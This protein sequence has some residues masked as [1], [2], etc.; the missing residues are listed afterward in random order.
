MAK[1]VGALVQFKRNL[2]KMRRGTFKSTTPPPRETRVTEPAP[3]PGRYWWQ[4]QE[5]DAEPM[6]P[7]ECAAEFAK[8]PLVYGGE[9]FKITGRARSDGPDQVVAYTRAPCTDELM[10]PH[11]EAGWVD[12]RYAQVRNR[13][14][15]DR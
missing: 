14:T 2:R 15:G 5:E 12:V 3:A 4:E 7:E 13:K 1:R 8:E 9:P 11:H 6:I 10:R